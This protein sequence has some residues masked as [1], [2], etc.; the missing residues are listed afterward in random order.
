MA[1]ILGYIAASL[2]QY[3]DRPALHRM[4]DEHGFEVVESRTFF[5]GVIE[6][7]MLRAT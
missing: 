5:F 2:G 6:R 7:V 1:K 4:L 3:P